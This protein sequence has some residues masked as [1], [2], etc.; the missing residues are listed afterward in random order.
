MTPRQT[1][2]AHHINIW[3]INVELSYPTKRQNY[4]QPN[5][6]QLEQQ[7]FFSF[8]IHLMVMFTLHHVIYDR[9]QCKMFNIWESKIMCLQMSVFNLTNIQTYSVYH[10]L[11]EE[12]YISSHLSNCNQNIS[13]YKDRNQSVYLSAC[14]Y[15][16]LSVLNRPILNSCS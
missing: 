3:N 13:L 1:V 15:G 2:A 8:L 16:C 14:I 6:L 10:H 7:Q 5:I 9:K 12:N 4:I 11:W